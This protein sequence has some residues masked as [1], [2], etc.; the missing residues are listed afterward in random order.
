MLTQFRHIQKGTL[1]VVTVIIVIAF[2]FLYSDFDF[3]SKTV[4]GQDCIVKVY[5][6]CYRQK[7]AQQLATNYDV[8]FRLG[9][10]DF[11]TSLFGERRQD[12]DRTDFIMS[13]IILRKEAEKMGIEPTAE[14]IKEAIPKLPIFQQPWMTA[15]L[16][17]NTIL[18]PNGFTEGDL[19]QLVKDYLCFQKM[20]DLIGSGV[21]AV[22]SEVERIYTKANQRYDASLINFDREKVLESIEITDAEISEYYEENKG[23]G[24][25]LMSD[26]KRGFEYA[27]FTPRE[28]AED[29]TNEAKAKADFDYRNAV[30]R[31]YSDLAD[32]EANFEEVAKQ[33]DGDQASFSMSYGKY[34]AFSAASPPEELEGNTEILSA[35]FS[36][37][38][39]NDEVTVP[40]PTS[41]GGGYYVF[42]VTSQVE[43]QLLTLEEATPKIRETLLARKSDREVNDAANAAKT[44]VAEAIEAGKSLEE[45]IKASGV[46]ATSIPNF[47]QQEPPVGVDDSSQIL[48]SVDGLG[49]KSVS[50][51]MKRPDNSGY[52]LVIVNDIQIYKDKDKTS[53]ERSIAAALE[54]ELKRRLF[55][56]WFNQR[57]AESSSE[58]SAVVP[59][60]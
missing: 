16:V 21:V 7:E 14:E 13:L 54:G 36:G 12:N 17:K 1:I 46:E 30:N 52:F 10:Y 3:V 23:D 29:A 41:E 26:P 11:A 18:G 4:G 28:L 48:A 5:D 39:E 50:D 53:A 20:R 9:M 31:A 58:R 32:D 42:H 43:P 37:I 24:I 44:K 33:Y 59:A 45:A 55:M 57:R 51:V 8:A 49:P 34:D 15:E 2:A 27:K 22:P 40:L 25:T 6:R 47:S 60:T 56:A 19:A 35:L 38:L